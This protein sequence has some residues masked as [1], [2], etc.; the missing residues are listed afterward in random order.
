MR[1]RSREEHLDD[2]LRAIADAAF[3]FLAVNLHGAHQ[4]RFPALLDARERFEQFEPIGEGR[5]V[6]VELAHRVEMQP[7]PPLPILHVIVRAGAVDDREP[8]LAGQPQDLHLGRVNL[9]Q[10]L[11]T[12]DDVNHARAFHDRSEEHALR[13]EIGVA[14]MPRDE[15]A[16]DARAAPALDSRTTARGSASKAF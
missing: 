1:E 11:R 15:L 3:P 4:L 13:L 9:E 8:R 7:E 5:V 10:R 16:K 12:I 14:A 6:R 2:D